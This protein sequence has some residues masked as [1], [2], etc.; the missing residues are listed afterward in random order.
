MGSASQSAISQVIS[1]VTPFVG[2]TA[3]SELLHVVS[4][5]RAEES[6]ASAFCDASVDFEAKE[7]LLT[8]VFPA[9]SEGTLKLLTVALA[10]RWSE[11]VEFVNGLEEVAV[12]VAAVTCEQIDDELLALAALIDSNHE[13]EL[14][15]ASKIET[16]EKKLALVAKLFET[17]VSTV[18]RL[19]LESVVA[20]PH[21]K[22]VSEK[23]R[24][25]A[26]TI[27]QQ[28]GKILALVTVAQPL[29]ED[30]QDRLEA[31]LSRIY[32]TPV[33]ISYL[34]DPSLVGG[35]RVQVG[36]EVIDGTIR[37]R[38]DDLRLQLIG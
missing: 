7:Q 19:I 38:L 32:D 20:F 30:R 3:A 12:R 21:G 37:Q 29:N 26:H 17:K 1:E 34:V 10:Q 4:Q 8:R 5:L 6:L 35:I 23:L 13:L 11:T 14:L 33:K 28:Q 31:S 27:V 25:F 9:L 15:L 18:A 22:R 24:F 2:F 16:A 36:D